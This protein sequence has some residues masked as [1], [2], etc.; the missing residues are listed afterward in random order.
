MSV[1]EEPTETPMEPS[2][3]LQGLTCRIT[4][5]VGDSGV[6][7]LEP[8]ISRE[9][10]VTFLGTDPDEWWT[11]LAGLSQALIAQREAGVEV[12]PGEPL[13][14]Q[15]GNVGW[16]VDR[17]VRFQVGDQEV[18]FRFSVVYGART[19]TGRWSTS[20]ARLGSQTTR[21]SGLP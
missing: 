14:Y 20:T 13:A 1:K 19:G 21:L 8:H 7:F 9:A 4:Q 18:P 3:E 15:E 12:I 10:D 16:A 17:S 5:A 11:D 6:T 2:P